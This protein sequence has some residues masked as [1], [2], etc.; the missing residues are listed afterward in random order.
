[1]RIGIVGAGPAGA[2]LA[3]ELASDGAT[4]TLFDHSHPREKP[5][6]GGL[7]AKAL[8]VLPDAPADDPLP[9]RPIDACVF[10]SGDGESVRVSLRRPVAAAARMD[11][12][13]WLLRRA[14]EAGARHRAQ[15]V[16]AVEPGRLRTTDGAE[17]AV[18]L[19]VGADGASSLVR[20]RFLG[21][22]PPQR[23]MM[24]AGWFARGTAAMLVRFTPGLE[25]Y[26]WLFPR[27]DHVGVGICAPLA[28]VPT[29]VL[30]ER[31]EHEVARHFPALLDDEAGKYAHTIPSPSTDPR[32]ILE[33]ADD[34]FA[35]VGDAAALADPITGEGI[36]YAL[37]S[38]RLLAASLREDGTAR[39]YPE[40]ALED[41]GRELLL[42]ARLRARFF[43]PGF[44]RRM[45]RY[46]AR[47]PAIRKVLADLVLGDQGYFGLKRRLLGAAPRFLVESA[48]HRFLPAA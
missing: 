43:G 10:E 7:T 3:R 28:S 1:M 20:R 44:S 33:I 4:V 15:R 18:D 47:S 23:L 17:H 2:F 5:C 21:P 39:R 14:L 16:V 35:L 19:V 36:Y 37:R 22:L 31:L 13:A 26:L 32:S 38:A 30:L 48:L 41:F 8:A 25:G 11:L 12:D 34:R 45:V 9:A 46:A 27:P 40:R 29:R 42:A 24:A 6:G